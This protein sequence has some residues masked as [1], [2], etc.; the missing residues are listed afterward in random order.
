MTNLKRCNK[1]RLKCFCTTLSNFGKSITFLMYSCI[2]QKHV[3]FLTCL[4]I[5]CI[6]I[7]TLCY[8]H[9]KCALIVKA[10]E[11]KIR[12][13]F[14]PRSSYTNE[15][16]T[17][18]KTTTKT[19][20]T[21]MGTTPTIQQQLPLLD[22]LNSGAILFAP[23]DIIYL[24]F[25]ALQTFWVCRISEPICKPCNDVYTKQY[26]QYYLKILCKWQCNFIL[27]SLAV[28]Q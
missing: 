7:C 17:T 16:T 20:A 13:L 28:L 1:I 25:L 14:L 22:N 18:N 12:H 19:T 2:S 8:K 10:S 11:S 5:I 27:D 23:R 21:T 6:I 4:K 24:I 9:K 15:T 3:G 26:L